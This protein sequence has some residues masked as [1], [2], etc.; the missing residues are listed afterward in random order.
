ME[1]LLEKLRRLFTVNLNSKEKG[2]I[3]SFTTLSKQA[4]ACYAPVMTLEAPTL[5]DLKKQVEKI[6]FVDLL[7]D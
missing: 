5:K 1:K 3:I 7:G 4:E 6:D 2:W